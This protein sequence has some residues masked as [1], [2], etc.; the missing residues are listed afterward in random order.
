M[1]GW[2]S[3]ARLVGASVCRVAQRLGA[4][5]SV[6]RG[7]ARIVISA[8]LKGSLFNSGDVEGAGLLPLAGVRGIARR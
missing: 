2:V 4:V 3:V 6:E 8:S 5:A 1:R 7:W